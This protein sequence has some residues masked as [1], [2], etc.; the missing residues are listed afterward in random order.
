MHERNTDAIVAN[1]QAQPGV[2]MIFDVLVK[3]ARSYV[4]ETWSTRRD[5]LESVGKG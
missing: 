1:A 5:A 4:N 3:G 2:M